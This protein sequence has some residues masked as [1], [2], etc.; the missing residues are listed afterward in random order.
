MT[1]RPEARSRARSSRSL[2][3]HVTRSVR[4]RNQTSPVAT[5]TWT[6]NHAPYEKRS[7]GVLSCRLT[8]LSLPRS[9]IRCQH[10]TIVAWRPQPP[11]RAA[12]RIHYATIGNLVQPT[13]RA[14]ALAYTPGPRSGEPNIRASDRA[15][16][17]LAPP[18]PNPTATR[19]SSRRIAC[20]RSSFDTRVWICSARRSGRHRP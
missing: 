12:I 13:I 9:V 19:E 20:R 1:P 5:A 11:R 3:C 17:A 7:T 16:R 14:F 10:S 18:G 6:S 2:P 8:I 15:A 4:P